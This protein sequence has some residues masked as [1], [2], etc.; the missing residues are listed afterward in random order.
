MRFLKTEKLYKVNSETLEIEKVKWYKS[1]WFVSIILLVIG[2]L[3]V[4]YLSKAND[5]LVEEN[6]K[7]NQGRIIHLE[8]LEDDER[9][10]IINQGDKFTEEKLVKMLLELNVKFPDIAFGQARYESGNWGTNPGANIFHT[11]SNLFGMRVA[12]TRPTTNIG[13]QNKHAAYLNWRQSVMDYA[14][15]Q[16]YMTRGINT[17]AE[18]FA[19]L[20][21]VYAEGSYKAI[22]QISREAREKYPELDVKRHPALEKVIIK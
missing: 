1:G 18:Y 17:R 2:F 6:R 13:E 19:Y 12:T 7:L 22:E 15:W 9:I 10:I 5:S 16:A 11:N 21:S 14:L 8:S 4:W 3:Y 20:K